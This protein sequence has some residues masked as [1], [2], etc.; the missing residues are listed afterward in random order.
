[1]KTTTLSNAV[2]LLVVM[3]I[4]VAPSVS[5][6]DPPADVERALEKAQQEAGNTADSIE[7]YTAA[8]R[9]AAVKK[10]KAMSDDLDARIADLKT[11]IERKWDQMDQSARQKARKA[12]DEL[13]K[14]RNEVA[15]WYGGLKHSSPRAWADVKEGFV[16]SYHALQDAFDKA[17]R[18]F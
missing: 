10:A 5:F 4:I 16:K 13:V 17:S 12:M 9:D 15:E 18:G 1:M 6:A 2:M 11:R 14:K 7:D 8:Q 3:A